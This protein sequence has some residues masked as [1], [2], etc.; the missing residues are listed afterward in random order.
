M[1]LELQ[2][3]WSPDVNPPSEGLPPDQFNFNVFVQFKVGEVGKA[4]GEVF[5]CRVCS[6]SALAETA[7]GTFVSSLVLARFDWSE[8]KRRLEKLLLHTAS[9]ENW[10][11]VI[12][13]L[14]PFVQYADGD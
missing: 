5:N 8:L 3:L 13:K 14:S 1:K 11:S 7:P 2:T 10:S 6:A 12:Q 9:S 4:G